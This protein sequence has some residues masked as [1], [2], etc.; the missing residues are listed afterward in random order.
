MLQ[1]Q[2]FYTDTT[3]IRSVYITLVLLVNIKLE[4]IIT[5]SSTIL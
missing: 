3:L 5:A 1:I 4:Y 2:K